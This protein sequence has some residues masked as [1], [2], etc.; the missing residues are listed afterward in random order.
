M[1]VPIRVGTELPA[2]LTIGSNVEDLRSVWWKLHRLARLVE[3]DPRTLAPSVQAVW[4]EYE[5][6]LI[7]AVASDPE[8]GLPDLDPLVEELV[9]RATK[10]TEL[11][12]DRAL[13]V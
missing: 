7:E 9:Q 1:F 12:D 8:S 3:L 2:P 11:L 6:A 13:A 10:L 5:T 4:S